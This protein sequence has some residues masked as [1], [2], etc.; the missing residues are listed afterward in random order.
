MVKAAASTEPIRSVFD[1]WSSTYDI[2]ASPFER[3]GLQLA[4]IQPHDALSGCRPVVMAPLAEQARFRDIRRE[5]R[6]SMLLP[7]EIV[8]VTKPDGPQTK[9]LRDM[10]PNQIEHYRNVVAAV[11]AWIKE[12][13]ACYLF[14][15]PSLVQD[16]RPHVDKIAELNKSLQAAAAKLGI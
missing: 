10:W 11:D 4:A 1:L 8:L 14:M 3:A 5:F 2:V 6:P 7:T 15:S 12:I 16:V 13:R 9:W